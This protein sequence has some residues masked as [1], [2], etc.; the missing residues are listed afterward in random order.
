MFSS[1]FLLFVLSVSKFIVSNGQNWNV[2]AWSGESFP[3]KDFFPETGIL[4][5]KGKPSTAIAFSGGGVNAYSNA[6]GIIAALNKLGVLKHIRYIAGTSGSAWFTG[7]YTYDQTT[8]VSD[9]I[10][11]GIIL[12]P[13]NF[14]T[15]SMAEVDSVHFFL[16]HN[17]F[18]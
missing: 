2:K 18:T 7:A 5:K 4:D 13:E 9:D 8:G 10:R 11:L 14:T 16:H 15:V 17:I 6:V 3:T 1:R 12:P